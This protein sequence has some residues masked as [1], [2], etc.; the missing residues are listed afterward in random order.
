MNPAME[1]KIVLATVAA[2]VILV[3]SLIPEAERRRG[4]A[5]ALAW[6]IPGAGH[7]FLGKWK[8]GL[9]FFALLGATYLFGLSIV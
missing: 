2:V 3:N 8:R 7:V 9:F 5:F 1:W 6:I 4:I